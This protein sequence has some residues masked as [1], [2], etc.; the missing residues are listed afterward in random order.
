MV[1]FRVKDFGA[2][3]DG[4]KHDKKMKKM[5]EEKLVLSGIGKSCCCEGKKYI[6]HTRKEE[7]VVVVLVDDT[8]VVEGYE[9][10]INEE[11]VENVDDVV[12]AVN[13]DVSSSLPS[14]IDVAVVFWT[15]GKG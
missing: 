14:S 4:T 1:S 11:E 7:E 5:E 9:V 2:E 8:D 13:D 6:V 15:R 12:C 3:R 10:G